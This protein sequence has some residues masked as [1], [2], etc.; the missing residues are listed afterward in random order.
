M[1]DDKTSH[2]V[3]NS[4]KPSQT[5]MWVFGCDS[6]FHVSKENRSK[7]YKNDEMC[8]FIGY[9]YGLKGYNL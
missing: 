6:F 2:E 8:I 3:W 4:N 1:L 9:K 7:L 5:H